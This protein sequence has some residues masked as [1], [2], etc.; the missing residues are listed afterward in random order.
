M[1]AHVTPQSLTEHLRSM[2]ISKSTPMPK[3]SK[4][5]ASSQI[6]EFHST[7]PMAC[8]SP[9]SS[10]DEDMEFHSTGSQTSTK[11]SLSEAHNSL[12][13]TQSLNSH[14]MAV[15]R[16]DLSSVP[17][18]C[19]WLE[20]HFVPNYLSNVFLDFLIIQKGCQDINS[21][22]TFITYFNARD[23]YGIL[24]PDLYQNY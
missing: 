14:I 23:V 10:K 18:F 7:T 19:Q 11:S 13:S 2:S 21:L 6:E 22:L 20:R 4:S 9:T 3:F 8:V 5:P 24:G 15:P 16:P 12:R 17:T 1:P